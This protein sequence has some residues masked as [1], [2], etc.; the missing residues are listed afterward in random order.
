MRYNVHD[1]TLPIAISILYVAL[2]EKMSFAARMN[3][4]ESMKKA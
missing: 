2:D 3:K 4:R 1:F